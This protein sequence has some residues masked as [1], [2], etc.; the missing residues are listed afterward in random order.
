M[1][2]LLFQTLSFIKM[3][4]KKKIKEVVTNYESGVFTIDKAIEKL[5]TLLLK[6]ITHED[7]IEFWGHTDVD[8]LVEKLSISPIENWQEIDDK[9][10]LLLINEILN[11]LDNDAII[12]RNSQ[13]L[14]KRFSKPNGFVDDCIFIED[15]N[16]SDLI[17]KKLKE[18]N[19]ILL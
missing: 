14:E 10:A 9:V 3:K 2:P 18:D 19:I 11:N 13:A 16:D 5:N 4:N 15:I 6:K 7:I 1:C 12:E 8:N 17:L